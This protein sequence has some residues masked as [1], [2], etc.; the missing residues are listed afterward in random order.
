MDLL[1]NKVRISVGDVEQ[2]DFWYQE[3]SQHHMNYYVWRNGSLD[4][5]NRGSRETISAV[6]KALKR[7][8]MN[9]K[10]QQCYQ[11]VEDILK[12]VNDLM[13]QYTKQQQQQQQQVHVQEDLTACPPVA[14]YHSPRGYTTGRLFR[15]LHSIRFFFM[16]YLKSI[17]FANVNV[18]LPECNPLKTFL[19]DLK[20]G[21]WS[22]YLFQPVTEEE[23]KKQ[24]Q[25][26]QQQQQL[27][28]QGN[29]HGY[30]TIID[31]L[32]DKMHRQMLYLSLTLT[33]TCCEQMDKVQQDLTGLANKPSSSSFLSANAN[34]NTNVNSNG[35][36]NNNANINFNLTSTKA[37]EK[38]LN[39]LKLEHSKL[40][41]SWDVHR[42]R[43]Q[44]YVVAHRDAIAQLK[45][46]F[47]Q[48]DKLCKRIEQLLV[49]FHFF[50]Y[51][52]CVY[53][54]MYVQWCMYILY[55]RINCI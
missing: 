37:L 53:T 35:N 22:T 42:E 52:I 19:Q 49:C 55:V 4:E 9:E 33:S 43:L 41:R 6:S 34:T 24:S 16:S 47:T 27:Q 26:Q 46:S 40:K 31:Y 25:Q 36:R 2:R 11:Y 54:Y 15:L 8:E 39:D 38:E 51:N 1:T 29:E 17:S 12:L 45:N 21:Q 20:S 18:V 14:V 13:K 7:D 3:L 32:I 23:K 50:K 28:G 5:L 48:R 30:V 44:E 10:E